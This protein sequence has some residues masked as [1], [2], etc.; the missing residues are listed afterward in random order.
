LR[1]AFRDG[2]RE[3]G[4]IEDKNVVI[5]T[6]YEGAGTATLETLVAELGRRPLDVSRGD[7]AG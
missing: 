1:K 3:H 6:R 5:E 2:F 4:W 7:H